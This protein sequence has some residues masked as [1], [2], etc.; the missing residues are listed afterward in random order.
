[1]SFR[2]L[3]LTVVA[4][5]A[6]GSTG[7]AAQDLVLTRANVVDV[8]EGS[9][10][11]DQTVVIR[12]G[13]IVSIGTEPVP[14]DIER[15][16]DLEGKFVT[17]GLMDGHV[18]IGSEAQAVRAL[19]SGVTTARSMGAS[20]YADVGLRDLIAAGHASGPEILAAG[21]HV[22][23]SPAEAFFINHP[24][25]GR[26]RTEEIRG[27]VA[28]EAMVSRVVGSGV[29]FVKTNATE[30]AGLPDTDPRRQL[31]GEAELAAIT[32]TAA[33]GGV[34]VAAHAHGEEGGRA[35]VAAGVRSIEHG[36]YLSEET[37][38]MMVSRGTYLVPTIAI[39]T[40]LA[41]PGGDYDVPFLRI[42]GRH[43]LPRLRETAA[44][45]HR[46]GVKIVAATD[47]GYGPGSVIRMAHELEE[48]VTVGMSPLEA[49]R[50]ATVTA[51][52]LFGIEDRT[53]RI[54]VGL[55]GDLVIVERN[56]LDDIGTMQD[57]LM[58]VSDGRV[59]HQIGDWP[60]GRP[61]S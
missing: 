12:D 13:R 40:D 22:R 58:V 7:L 60:E 51:A 35:A 55:E 52:E 21:Y 59:A 19:R 29:D 14:S 48:L 17:P 25:M 24:D 5:L 2:R 37:L 33:A 23:P 36:S 44:N 15:V 32:R 27:E 31:Y 61:V 3:S 42:R 49:L 38:A 9:V 47:T 50:S 45:A 34:P 46:M 56:P 43:M 57:I 39:V 20:N 10:A 28:L 8:V 53:G 26:Y 16:I 1:M 18:H 54:A 30:R 6:G 11:M 41:A 4:L